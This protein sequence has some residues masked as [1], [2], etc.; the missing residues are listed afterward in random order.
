MDACAL[1][2]DGLMT[3][4]N[5]DVKPSHVFLGPPTRFFDWGDVVVSHPLTSLASVTRLAAASGVAVE[6][7][8]AP[9]GVPPDSDRARAGVVLG[10][11]IGVDVW[12]RDMPGVFER[13]PGAM[14]RAITR[15]A[16]SLEG[17]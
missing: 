3:L 8:V 6:R 1:L 15:L 16:D 13:H 14:G 10:E 17:Y 12:M 9:W 4:I 2:D 7:A 11:L 5:G